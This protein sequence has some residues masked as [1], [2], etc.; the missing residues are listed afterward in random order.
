MQWIE[1]LASSLSNQLYEASFPSGG[2][3][4]QILHVFIAR[5][6]Q[7]TARL[8]SHRACTCA[9][10]LV[11][12]DAIRGC[13]SDEGGPIRKGRPSGMWVEADVRES[14]AKRTEQQREMPHEPP[15]SAREMSGGRLAM[16]SS[17][18]L[19]VASE[20]DASTVASM[21]LKPEEAP[22]VRLWIRGM[23]RGLKW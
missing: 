9:V 4:T 7:R 1:S 23:I 21:A 14:I 5:H 17:W 18:S 12:H 11:D 6:R 3:H 13:G 10:G 22:L 20:Q 19:T 16:S 15:K 8:A 2:T